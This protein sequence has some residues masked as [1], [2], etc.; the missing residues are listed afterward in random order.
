MSKYFLIS[1]PFSSLCKESGYI[2]KRNTGRGRVRSCFNEFS[3]VVRNLYGLFDEFHLN[4]NEK[5]HD[6]GRWPSP[7]VKDKEGSK[8][9]ALRRLK[10]AVPFTRKTK[11]I[12]TTL[13]A[14]SF[15]HKTFTTLTTG[16]GKE[17]K[18]SFT[19]K[20]KVCKWNWQALT[21]FRRMTIQQNKLVMEI[22]G[23]QW[24]NQCEVIQLSG[25]L[26]KCL[27]QFSNYQQ[28][29]LICSQVSLEMSM[30]RVELARITFH[31]AFASSR[32]YHGTRLR[33]SPV[34]WNIHLRKTQ[35]DMNNQ[36]EIVDVKSNFLRE[37]PWSVWKRQLGIKDELSSST[38]EWRTDRY[39]FSEA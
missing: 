16:K 20:F 4:E 5:G 38:M 3:R 18:K 32:R 19:K 6:A 30:I 17:E 8:R 39:T 33:A 26:A 11:S 35:N 24:R 22:W 14:N 10:Q 36:K 34:I 15:I 2:K 29:S 9:L 25:Y 12:Q 28:G 27:E 1:S 7:F 13:L 21:S 37:A 23:W 31:D